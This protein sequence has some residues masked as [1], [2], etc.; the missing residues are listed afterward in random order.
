MT[1]NQKA[2]DPDAVNIKDLSIVK[3]LLLVVDGHLRQLV[4]AVND[5]AVCFS[6]Q[7][8]VLDLAN[9]QLCILKQPR[10]V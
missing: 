4:K 7:I 3:Q 10:T 6:G 8:P 2:L 5:L 9:V 1:G